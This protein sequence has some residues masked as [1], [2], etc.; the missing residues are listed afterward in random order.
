MPAARS[1]ARP[2]GLIRSDVHGTSKV[3]VDLD[4]APEGARRSA[5][6]AL[7]SSSAGQPTN[8]GRISTRI[9]PP[10]GADVDAWT[11]PRSTTRASGAPGPGPRR[12]RRGRPPRR[13]GAR[14]GPRRAADRR[15][16]CARHARSGSRPRSPGR[17]RV[18]AADRGEL[19]PQPAEVGAVV[20]PAALGVARRRRHRQVEVGEDRGDRRRASGARARPSARP[21]SR[22][23]RGRPRRRAA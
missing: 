10:S 22:P 18:G 12:V 21:G 4:R 17:S 6:D 14:G 3:A 7:M 5:I 20:E 16:P 1:A 9:G 11:I 13:R 19:A 8:V 23:R 2:A 15:G